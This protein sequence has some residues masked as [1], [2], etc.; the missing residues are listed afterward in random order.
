MNGDACLCGDKTTWHPECYR[1]KSAVL[2]KTIVSAVELLE[3]YPPSDA[4]S[5]QQWCGVIH[6][7]KQAIK[8]GGVL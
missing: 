8:T 1:G 5:Y 7:L 4:K 3:L 2:K 6:D